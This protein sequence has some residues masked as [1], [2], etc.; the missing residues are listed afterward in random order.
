MTDRIAPPHTRRS[1]RRNSGAKTVGRVVTRSLAVCVVALLALATPAFAHR[2]DEYLQATT[3]DVGRDRIDLRVRLTAGVASATKVLAAIDVNGDNMISDAEQRA[4]AERVRRDLSLKLDGHDAPLRLV[5]FAYPSIADI[6]TG[7]GDI[8]LQFATD[9]APRSAIRDLKF[10]NHHQ[11]ATPVY[12]VNTLLPS[13]TTVHILGQD[14]N[15]D[16]SSYT[17]QFA[18]GT[19]PQL[20]V[21]TVSAPETAQSLQQSEASSVIT[22]YFWHG[23]HHILTGYDHL[24]FLPALVHGALTLWDLVKVVTAFTIAHSITLTLAALNLVHLPGR[25]VEP[26]IAASIVFIAVQNVFWPNQAH[27]RSRLIIAFLFGLF[28]GLGFAGGLL[29]IMHQMPTGLVLLAILGFS[30]GVEA[31]NQLVLLPLFGCIKLARRA[32]A[33]VNGAGASQSWPARIQRV[34]SAGISVA[35]VY[36]LLLA[37]VG[38]S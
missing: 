31:G 23:I 8:V 3:I 18:I 11:P 34:G 7:L 1:T 16:Q 28:H 24:L 22:T 33:A 37:L 4:Y 29:E 25:V 10:Q 21:E 38:A 26:F 14:R 9:I 17:M 12:L 30:L 15:R 5:S 27:G 6:R 35:G 2:L 20:A 36:Y 13:D 19:L 32:R